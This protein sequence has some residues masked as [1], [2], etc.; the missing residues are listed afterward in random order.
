MTSRVI[1]KYE[2]DGE[3]ARNVEGL[4]DDAVPQ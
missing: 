1:L 2:Y 4:L 3:S